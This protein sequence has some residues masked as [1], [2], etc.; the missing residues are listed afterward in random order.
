MT[1]PDPAA[2]LPHCRH[3]DENSCEQYRLQRKRCQDCPLLPPIDAP[4]IY[5]T[6]FLNDIAMKA[7]HGWR[8][9]DGS[10]YPPE[11]GIGA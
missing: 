9:N 2:T 1:A 8:M 5:I 6:G 11:M 3:S 7:M 4:P 10:I